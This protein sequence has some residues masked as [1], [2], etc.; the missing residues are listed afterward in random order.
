MISNNLSISSIKAIAFKYQ[1]LTAAN[2]GNDEFD[3]D[4][5]YNYDIEKCRLN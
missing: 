2:N 3:E 5:N 4:G 1:L